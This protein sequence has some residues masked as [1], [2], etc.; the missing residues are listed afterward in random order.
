MCYFLPVLGWIVGGAVAHCAA[1]EVEERLT[2]RAEAPPAVQI[3][4]F[5]R[6][7]WKRQGVTPASR[8][9]DRTFVRRVYL[10]LAG[11][12][13]TVSEVETFLADR[14]LSRRTHLVDV[15]LASEDHVE[16]MADVLDVELMGRAGPGKQAER[17]KHGWRRYLKDAI[18]KD[19]PWNEVTREILLARPQSKDESGAVWFLYERNNQHQAIAESIAPAFFG[20]RVECAQ[21]HDHMLVDEIKQAHYWGTRGVLQP[22]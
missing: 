3:N 22:R 4:H 19:R 7:A 18:R 15:L 10:D 12:V 20:I 17:V 21:C 11:R 1:A 6:N 14:R 13:P 9:D 5:I 2:D 16:H 8:C